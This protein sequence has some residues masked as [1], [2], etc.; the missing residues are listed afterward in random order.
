MQGHFQTMCVKNADT[1]VP[2]NDP[3]KTFPSR[4]LEDLTLD[5]QKFSTSYIIAGEIVAGILK[6][7][8]KQCCQVS[9]I[10]VCVFWLSPTLLYSSFPSL[11][12]L[13]QCLWSLIIHFKLRITI[14]MIICNFTCHVFSFSFL[15]EPTLNICSSVFR[16]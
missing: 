16:H 1:T 10:G 14:Y 9:S 2:K 6:L 8:S 3:N 5:W 4:L 11:L 7:E 15:P 12:G 13:F